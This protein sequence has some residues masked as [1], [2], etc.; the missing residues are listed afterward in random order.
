[1]ETINDFFKDFKSRLANPL[2]SSFIFSWLIYNWQIP[3]VVFLYDRTDLM[4]EGHMTY[5]SFIKSYAN[6]GNMT[7]PLIPAIIYTFA[8]PY[9]KAFIKLYHAKIKAG[10]DT[11][12]LR[13]T[14]SGMMPVSAY[15]AAKEEQ[16]KVTAELTSVLDSQKTFQYENAILQ[17]DLQKVNKASTVLQKA[18]EN[19]TRELKFI[20]DY[21]SST[22]LNGIWMISYIVLGGPETRLII[23]NSDASLTYNE[24]RTVY[25]F[26]YYNFNMSNLTLSFVLIPVVP[27]T[28][29]RAFHLSF[30]PDDLTE[31]SGIT[32][33]G[34]QIKLRKG[35]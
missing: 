20:T 7:I 29:T 1:M 2:F 14:S 25:A 35:K 6:F 32:T 10:N 34:H 31:M 21:S 3:M 16:A 30:N 5:N 18:F 24:V 13:A 27:D 9:L 33:N 11:Q 23:S 15:L 28:E 4:H 8:I 17:S 22:I 19:S 12:I 26:S